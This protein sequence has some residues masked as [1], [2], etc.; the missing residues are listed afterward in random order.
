MLDIR[1]RTGYLFLA[2]MVGHVILISAQV[3]TKEGVRV[4]ETVTFGVFAEVQRGG[5]TL[6]GGWRRIWSGYIALRGLRAENET[7]K[8]RLSE[9]QVRLQEERA[10][11]QR[12]ERLQKLLDLKSSVG[13]PTLAAEVIAGDATPGFPNVTINKGERDG[14]RPDMAVISPSGV[15]G[16]LVG[17]L[18][19]HAARVQLIIGRNAGAGATIERSRA[20]GV[21]VGGATDP[22]LLMEY[23]SNLADV[24]SGDL[25]VTAGT[26]GIYPKGFAI[27]RVE[28]ADRGAG[29]Y[30]TITVRPVVDFSNIEEVLVVLAPPVAPSPTA[31]ARAAAGGGSPAGKR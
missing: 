18:A 7:L 19:P 27:G 25:V 21:I 17:P 9:L 24:R 28:T 5:A 11:A 15:V 8:Q 6:I 23:V 13:L 29:L 12:T 20:G 4:L 26:D 1:Q 3:Q 31:Q 14:L 10:L 30:K 16:R 2:V 22:P